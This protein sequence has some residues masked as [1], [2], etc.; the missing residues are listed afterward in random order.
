[1]GLF[2]KKYCDI[3]GEKIGL[4]GNRK[5][6]DG[7]LCKDCAKKLSR[8]FNERRHSNVEEIKA[9]LAY[10]EENKQRVAQFRKT[11]MEGDWW[12]VLFDENNRW[13]CVTQSD[14]PNTDENPDIIDFSAVTGCHMDIKED[15]DEIYYKDDDGNERSYSPPCYE[16][17]YDFRITIHV[18]TPYFDEISFR[19]NSTTVR[20]NPMKG[21]SFSSASPFSSFGRNMGSG[22]MYGGGMSPE[23]CRY[24]DIGQAICNLFENIQRGTANYTNTAAFAQAPQ[25][26]QAHQAPQ[27]NA[28]VWNCANCGTQNSGKFCENCGAGRPATQASGCTKCGW[29]PPTG[30]NK[31]KFCPECGTPL[32]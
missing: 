9:Q 13:F 28:A 30:Q 32:A 25:A 2:D 10:R 3:C 18:N 23:Y 22:S 26:Q 21:S 16:Y 27:A 15:R 8:W 12:K 29:T 5:L 14:N 6:E 31:P 24:R 11:R 1:M 4:L 7:N 17:S 20:Y 19:L